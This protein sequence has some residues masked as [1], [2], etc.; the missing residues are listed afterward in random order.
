MVV[1]LMIV[2]ISVHTIIII[3]N[4]VIDDHLQNHVNLGDNEIQIYAVGVLQEVMLSLDSVSTLGILGS[5]GVKYTYQQKRSRLS[6]QRLSP[7]LDLPL[8][9]LAN[10]KHRWQRCMQHKQPRPDR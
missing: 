8:S 6:F 5:K 9:C 10:R 3:I 1:V 4:T 2:T 7:D